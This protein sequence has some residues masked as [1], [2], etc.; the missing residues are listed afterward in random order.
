MKTRLCATLIALLLSTGLTAGLWAK[1]AQAAVFFDDSFEG[2]GPQASGWGYTASYCSSSPCPWL[3]VSTD[4]AYSG[5][6]SLKGTYSAGFGPPTPESNVVIN[7]VGIYRGFAPTV[8]LYNRYYYRTNGFTYGAVGTKHIYWKGNPGYPNFFSINWWGSS[9]LGFA[10]QNLADCGYSSCNFYPN[11][12]SK[13]FA[14]NVWYCV[15]EHVKLNTPG[16]ADGILEVWIDGTQTLGYYN[17]TFR[18]TAVNGP[19]GNSSTM[20]F[21]TFE[22]YKQ[23][24]DGLM[25]YDQFAAG[26]TRIGC[27][28]S[29]TSSD[30]TPPA[31]PNG[32]VIR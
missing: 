8:D 26:N 30:T 27:G 31:A 24:G 12:A 17:R 18:G 10:G 15:E 14:N 22:I 20:S 5:S 6:K 11:M 9:E 2:S 32:L 1:P 19:S 28:G 25:Y 16:S 7:T 23:I 29:P 3:D 13:P 4:V 21:N